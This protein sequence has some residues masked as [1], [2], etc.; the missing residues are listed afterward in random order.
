MSDPIEDMK[1]ALKKA[2]RGGWRV[3]LKAI[4][5]AAAKSLEEQ[6]KKF[7]VSTEDGSVEIV[8]NDK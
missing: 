1:D 3:D 4:S 8:E 7:S 2:G 5:E 6:K